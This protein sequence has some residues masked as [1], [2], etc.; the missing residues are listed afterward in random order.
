MLTDIDDAFK[1]FSYQDINSAFCN[2]NT[3]L[4]DIIDNHAPQMS[5]VVTVKAYKPWY[6]A[7]LSQ[8]NDFGANTKKTTSS[9]N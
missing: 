1:K 2:Y 7:E 4:A 5:Q 3:T 6:T 8:Q 9:G